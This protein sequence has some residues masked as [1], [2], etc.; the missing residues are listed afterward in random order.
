VSEPTLPQANIGELKIESWL[1]FGK[2]KQGLNMNI[3]GVLIKRAWLESIQEEHTTKLK[4]R[5]VEGWQREEEDRHGGN[6][7]TNGTK[8]NHFKN[9]EKYI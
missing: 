9:M 5:N 6:S 3:C 1:L 2:T 8:D 7:K 4:E